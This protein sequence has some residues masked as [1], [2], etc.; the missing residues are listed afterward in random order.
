MADWARDDG[1]LW[2]DTDGR[3]ERETLIYVCGRTGEMCR[4]QIQTTFTLN[5]LTDLC[6]TGLSSRHDMSWDAG[7]I[8]AVMQRPFRPI[9][10]FSWTLRFYDT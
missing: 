1:E 6:I 10:L 3:M 4:F 5:I 7:F 8:L 2:T 9:Q